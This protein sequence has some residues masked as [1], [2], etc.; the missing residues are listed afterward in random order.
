MSR[1]SN[2]GQG[3]SS[4]NWIYK[5][6]QMYIFADCPPS[7]K[8]QS[9]SLTCSSDVFD[10][11]FSARFLKATLHREPPAFQPVSTH[12]VALY[13]YCTVINFQVGVYHFFQLIIKIVTYDFNIRKIVYTI[14]NCIS[15][16]THASETSVQYPICREVNA[17]QKDEMQLTDS[18]VLCQCIGEAQR[19]R[20]SS[21]ENHCQQLDHM[22]C[23]QTHWGYQSSFSGFDASV[24]SES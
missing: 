8:K 20:A 11:P 12:T 10:V 22:L 23:G 19:Q 16:V 13:R 2:Q 6:N 9:C 1:S 18:C 14:V 17:K 4:K 21:P 24:D 5:H 7:V 15:L 3:H